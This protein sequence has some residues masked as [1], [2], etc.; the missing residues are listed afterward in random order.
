MEKEKQ[1]L[2]ELLEKHR[3]LKEAVYE[4]AAEIWRKADELKEAEVQ[5]ALKQITQKELNKLADEQFE[6]QEQDVQQ[7]KELLIISEAVK[8]QKE[9]VYAL[10]RKHRQEQHAKLACDFDKVFESF[11]DN[12]ITLLLGIEGKFGSPATDPGK[13]LTGLLL[14]SG[15][16]VPGVP[17]TNRTEFI[18]MMQTK[19]EE[20]ING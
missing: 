6:R 12:A 2:S 3:A 10:E 7:R 5:L 4:S 16:S 17:Q 1:L 14:G 19:R 13:I 11:R 8:R 15:I 18:N 20:L 9:T